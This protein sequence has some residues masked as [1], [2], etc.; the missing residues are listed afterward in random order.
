MEILQTSTE[1]KD[2]GNY[3]VTYHKGSELIEIEEYIY[4][5]TIFSGKKRQWKRIYIGFPSRLETALELYHKSRKE[6]NL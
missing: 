1:F 3:R 2:L 5:N 4:L 6:H